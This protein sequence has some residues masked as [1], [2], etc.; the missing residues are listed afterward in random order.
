[1]ANQGVLTQSHPMRFVVS[2]L[3]KVTLG[4]SGLV[5]VF[6][7]LDYAQLNRI[8]T[9]FDMSAVALVTGFSLA[10]YVFLGYRL[11]VCSSHG[12]SVATGTLA[13]LVSHGVNNILP[14]KLGEVAKA[15]YI[16]T[17]ENITK[18]EALGIVFW[19][20]FLDLNAILIIA[21]VAVYQIDLELVTLPLCAA[22]LS[23]WLV[24]L[25][26]N[27]WKRLSENVICL[28]PFPGIQGFL[29]E[30]HGHIGARL[31][32]AFLVKIS[33]LTAMVWVLYGVQAIYILNGAANLG[34][35]LEQAGVVFVL[36]SLS[37]ALPTTP[38]ALGVFEAVVVL[39]LGWY[40]VQKE[41]AVLTAVVMHMVE[42]IPTCVA[43]LFILSRTPLRISGWRTA[44]DAP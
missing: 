33:C 35:T 4:I 13:T 36:S 11:R 8:V 29:R 32:L 1:M 15:F 42:F 18:A 19:E 41:V 28:L 3:L 23:L 20:R 12:M 38:G 5:Y 22:V 10:V 34:L 21:A 2:T 16:N 24:I 7:G 26:A 6:W 14:T 39:S 25:A 31:S 44:G 37:M 27:R 9:D 43:T 30:L 40:G 17:R